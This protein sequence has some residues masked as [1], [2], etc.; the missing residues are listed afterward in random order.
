[1]P[2]KGL[3]L[4][5]YKEKEAY[6]QFEV[7]IVL[8]RISFENTLIHFFLQLKRYK[9]Y[10]YLLC[11]RLNADPD[12]I[13]DDSNEL[14][15]K[16]RPPSVPPTSTNLHLN[17]NIVGGGV[18]ASIPLSTSPTTGAGAGTQLVQPTSPQ[19][20]SATNRYSYRAAIYRSEENQQH[21]DIG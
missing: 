11:S 14:L 13:E 4:Q 16:P 7:I 10:V 8:Q 5:N 15:L 3:A 9:T 2:T 19:S 20:H 21:H 18:G 6:L 1:L 17:L 12:S